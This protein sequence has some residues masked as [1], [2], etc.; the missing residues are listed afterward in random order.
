MVNPLDFFRSAKR[1]KDDAA[2]TEGPDAAEG[3]LRPGEPLPDPDTPASPAAE[4]DESETLLEASA[5]DV[6]P[7]G[8]D[9]FEAAV[10]DDGELVLEL[11]DEAGPSGE[12]VYRIALKALQQFY[13]AAGRL[14]SA[15]EAGTLPIED[16][17]HAA[18]L[19]VARMEDGDDLM[20]IAV[21]PYPSLDRFV[22]YHSV[23]V[24]VLAQRV[25]RG[26]K[27]QAPEL[28]VLCLAALAHD[29]GTVRVPNEVFTKSESLSPEEWEI[30]RQR[31]VHSRDI[32]VSLGPDYRSIAEIAH[33]VYERLD[34]SGYP[35]QLNVDGVSLEASI[36]G[37]VD[38]FEAIIHPRPYKKTVPAAAMYGVDNMMRM[39]NQFGD[40]VLKS[41]VRGV[42]L[43]PVGTFVRLNSG[44]VA[45]VAKS[46]QGNPMRPTVEVLWD[47][48][49]Q[50]LKKP[51]LL[52][53]MQAPH[54]YVYRPLST[55]DLRELGLQV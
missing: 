46:R 6:Q 44:E 51:K 26:L 9:E 24:A 29:I 47:T 45:R 40:G 36:I 2:E 22:L 37:A 31:P 32:L 7:L 25:A 16:M 48:Q 23:N 43:F 33:Q 19:I 42:G 18:K 1:V 35:R 17:D 4:L 54:L 30:I 53:L 55:E 13:V 27:M 15:G 10:G 34:G 11:E 41:L 52:D 49:K 12:E 8:A 38:L 5:E 3:R 21:G 50:A 14:T 20:A 28:E 39:S